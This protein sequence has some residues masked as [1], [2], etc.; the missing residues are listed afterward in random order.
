MITFASRFIIF[1]SKVILR[2]WHTWSILERSMSLV[3][4]GLKGGSTFLFSNCTQ[5]ILA[6]KGWFFISWDPLYPRR[7]FGFL[8]RSPSIRLHAFSE[9]IGC[10]YISSSRIIC[11]FS[12]LFLLRTLNGFIPDSISYIIRP[13]K[14]IQRWFSYALTS[15]HQSTDFPWPLPLMISGAKYSGVPQKV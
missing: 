3:R 5:S 9:K 13:Y 1:N 7:Y 15:D 10:I 11:S 12:N 6:K 8:A 14:H 2:I 4:R